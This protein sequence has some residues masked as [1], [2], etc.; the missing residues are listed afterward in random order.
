MFGKP[1]SKWA[2]LSLAAL[3]LIG[4][5]P[6]PSGLPTPASYADLLKACDQKEGWRDPAPPVRINGNVYYVGTCGISS[7]L[8]TSPQGHVLLDSAEEEAVPLILANIARLGFDPRDIKWLL[9][10]HSHFD[11]AGGLRAMQAATGARIAALP[12]Q[13]RELERGTVASDDPQSGLI[14]PIAAVRVDRLLLDGVP[15]QLGINRFTAVAT[16]GH[17]RGSTSWVIRGCGVKNCPA[18]VY[19]DSTS[20]VSAEGYRFTDHP[21]WVAQFRS[22]VARIGTLP[23]AILV[24]PHPGAS[25]LFERFAG[26]APLAAKDQCA[27]YA[28]FSLGKLDERLAKEASTR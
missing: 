13:A 6:M 20:A 8:V 4:A 17:T 5:R 24:T 9:T 10:S 21:A 25:E 28:A 11:H 16:P 15:L 1:M 7:L 22:G 2:G 26:D 3:S 12:D 23:C 14:K 19:A 27:R 18:V